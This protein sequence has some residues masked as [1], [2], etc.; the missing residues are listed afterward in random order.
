MKKLLF[1]LPLLYYSC[2]DEIIEII[3]DIDT[4]PPTISIQ[5]LNAGDYINE[6][7]LISVSVIDDVEIYKVEFFIDDS[8]QF[9]D[10][11]SPYEFEFDGN[12]FEDST[13]VEFKVK[14]YDT[15][16]NI[17]I[18]EIELIVIKNP[19]SIFLYTPVIT[20]NY[21]SFSWS[22]STDGDF[23]TYTLYASE[24]TSFTNKTAIFSSADIH[25]T[26]YDYYIESHFNNFYMVS[27][28]D[29]NGYS[30]NSNIENSWIKFTIDTGD[31]DKIN[32]IKILP[33]STYLAFSYQGCGLRNYDIYGNEI[34]FVEANGGNN[35]QLFNLTEDGGV[36]LFGY[37]YSGNSTS[38]N[39]KKLN[40]SLEIEWENENVFYG[41]VY[42]DSIEQ[43]S[44][45]NYL[46]SATKDANDDDGGMLILDS[47]GG[48]LLYLLDY[49]AEPEILSL[50]P[51]YIKEIQDGSFIMIGQGYF[52]EEDDTYKS[53]FL[54]KTDSDGG[55]QWV[56]HTYAKY[57]GA[58][59]DVGL[60]E[61]SGFYIEETEDGDFLAVGYTY[62]FTSSTIY[63]NALLVSFNSN[64]NILWT[65]HYPDSNRN[66]C[67][68][69]DISNDDGLILGGSS[70]IASTD[71]VGNIIWAIDD[72][73]DRI[74]EVHLTPDGGY[75]AGGDGIIIKIDPFGNY[76][77]NNP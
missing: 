76:S 13:A 64:G 32:S 5:S 61:D 36:I 2:T 12:E 1:I 73:A 6:Y 46:I 44:N 72:L 74:M 59:Q 41:R 19:N 57:Y 31:W 11:E 71:Q 8:L 33:D 35:C 43:V 16:D 55:F 17:S 27:V 68:Y 23:S 50:Y 21:F 70:F 75:I 7:E 22:K 42:F 30:S 54:L 15:S 34:Q 51:N 14:S 62:K 28:T 45:G 39:I 18:A 25:T 49:D 48:L 66:Y 40:S 53:L 4:T 67:N 3:P 38:T 37:G 26:N 56:N 69:V 24:D 47:N 10:L 63:P 29:L 52:K 58:V 9:I 77:T 20:E 65:R 60:N